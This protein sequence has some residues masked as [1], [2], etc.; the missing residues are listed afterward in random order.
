M[1]KRKTLILFLLGI[2]TLT[3]CGKNSSSEDAVSSSDVV[4]SSELQVKR[5]VFLLVKLNVIRL[6]FIVKVAQA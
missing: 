5:Q 2:L 3:G 4:S 6:P 1:R